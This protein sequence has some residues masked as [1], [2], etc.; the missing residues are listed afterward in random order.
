MTDLDLLNIADR[1]N[2]W[3]K[4]TAEYYGMDKDDLQEIIKS[5][6]Q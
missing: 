4:E 5:F 2:Q 6:L 3:L 1:F